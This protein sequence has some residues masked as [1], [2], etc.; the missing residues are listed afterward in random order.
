M[1]VEQLLVLR[2]FGTLNLG[3]RV[4]NIP[5]VSSKMSSKI[6]QISN[7]SKIFMKSS[8]SVSS[9]LTIF[10]TLVISKT[11]ISSFLPRL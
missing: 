8:S 2:G 4:H 7:Q 10:G 11:N 1:L 9:S 6:I 5:F 3:P